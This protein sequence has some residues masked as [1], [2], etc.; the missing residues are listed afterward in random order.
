MSSNSFETLQF[1]DFFV[2]NINRIMY[3]K[4]WTIRKLSEESNVPYDTIKK[5]V[6][7]KINNPRL[8]NSLKIANALD[9]SLDYLLGRE[10][11]CV[12]NF[13]N[14]PKRAYTLLTEIANFESF[15][16]TNNLKYNSDYIPVLVPSGRMGDEMIF[17]G[18]YTDC[19]DISAYRAEF[20]NNIM[21]GIRITNQSLHPTFLENDIL[22]IAR[23]R[24][25][26]YGETGI[27][28]KSPKV[29]IRKYIY[30]SPSILEPINGVGFPI[31]VDKPEDWYIFGR[32]LTIIRK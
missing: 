22:L 17:E 25:P 31:I 4:G 2:C 26:I 6:S 12:R 16:V 19:V 20:G 1:K 9:C 23:D 7:G 29:Y 11:Y 15:L 27:F 13:K 18:I 30:G 24:H 3:E 5:L 32:V 14:L 8:C 28:L 10:H 21:C